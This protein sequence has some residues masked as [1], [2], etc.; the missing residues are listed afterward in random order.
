MTLLTANS[1][2]AEEVCKALGLD[3]RSTYSVEFKI[4][5]GHI[6]SVSARV[7]RTGEGVPSHIQLPPKLLKLCTI[8]KRYELHE[9]TK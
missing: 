2:D 9:I 4:E 8:L 5:A 6:A 1:H 7:Y 3:P